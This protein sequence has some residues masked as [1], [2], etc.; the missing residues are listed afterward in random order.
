MG[1]GGGGRNDRQ[2]IA[3]LSIGVLQIPR[4]SIK[5][6]AGQLYERSGGGSSRR[7]RAKMMFGFPASQCNVL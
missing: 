3:T 4:H 7:N 1:G 5:V 6:W 2:D